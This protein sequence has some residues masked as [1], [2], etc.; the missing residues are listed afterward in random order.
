MCRNEAGESGGDAGA[1]PGLSHGKASGLM[2]FLLRV[3]GGKYD[4]SYEYTAGANLSICRKYFLGKC[5][6]FVAER[7]Q[8]FPESI[9]LLCE[10]LRIF[11]F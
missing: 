1:H 11:F 7:E 4:L 5:R 3:C 6:S 8:I 2:E 10:S 9:F